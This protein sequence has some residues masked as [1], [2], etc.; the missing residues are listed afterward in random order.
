MNKISIIK[1]IQKYISENIGQYDTITIEDQLFLV[2]KIEDAECSVVLRIQNFGETYLV[3]S[4]AITIKKKDLEQQFELFLFDELKKYYNSDFTLSIGAASLNLGSVISDYKI[5]T[6]SD[7]IMLNNCLEFF[8]NEVQDT[9][10][11]PMVDVRSIANYISKYSYES[12]LKVLVGSLFPVNN[13]KKMF[14]LYKGKE[15][16]RYTEY[17]EGLYEQLVSFPIRKPQRKEEA[18]YFIENF[19]YLVNELEK[20]SS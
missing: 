19:L 9:Y 1:E 7:V 13:F 10:F 2:R 3:N 15:I 14:L 5:K 17:K 6:A 20:G 11:Y 12:N 16:N 18:K 8:L 4:N